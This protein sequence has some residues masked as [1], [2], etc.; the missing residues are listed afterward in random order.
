MP[1]S[2][3]RPAWVGTVALIGGSLAVW[4]GLS[5]LLSTT[6]RAP[7]HDVVEI[8][9]RF[10]SLRLSKGL[11]SAEDGRA[12]GDEQGLLGGGGLAESAGRGV[13]IGSGGGLSGSFGAAGGSFGLASSRSVSRPT[14]VPPRDVPSLN[15]EE[16]GAWTSTSQD[17]V[18][19]FAA[20]VDTG[21]YTYARALL[22][23]GAMPD[24][25][26]VRVE[27]FV[28]Y[29]R[30]TAVSPQSGELFN[31]QSDVILPPWDGG[32]QLVRLTVGSLHETRRPPCHLTFLVDTSGSMQ[33][34]H[35]LPLVREGLT[36]LVEALEEG[37]TVAIVAYAGSAGL[38][39]PPTDVRRSDRILESIENLRSGGS[40]AMGSGIQLAYDLAERTYEP[41][42]VNRVVLLSD[43][44][45]NVGPT[46]H[47]PLVET[48]RH[49]ASQGIALTT[50]GVGTGNY[51]DDMM[52]RLAD[53]GDGNYVYVDDL[54]EARRVFV[55]RLPSTLGVLARDVKLQVNWSP[56]TVSAYR[57]IGYENRSIADSDFRVDSVDAGEVGPGHQ[58][59][60]LYEIRPAGARAEGL[61]RVNIR[62]KPPG[63]DAPAME[64]SFGIT[65]ERAE[66]WDVASADT[67]LAVSAAVFADKLR[68]GPWS[69][70]V[71]W[72]QLGGWTNALAEGSSED[73]R[74]LAE[75]VQRIADRRDG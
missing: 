63:P 69:D 64:R 4:G 14:T 20:D 11:Q 46:S 30:Y 60:A 57:L 52:E 44:D 45:A 47:G 24:A 8:P 49:Y 48:V 72:A 37:D 35:K 23:R 41:G 59:T 65:D 16:T 42:Q 61:G 38:V 67:R 2:S 3:S 58:I 70:E 74:E 36:L 39:L 9:D 68:R 22:S 10:L 75:M 32:T 62:Y 40:T 55:H 34:Q 31:L 15:L 1:S 12:M 29:F 54:R 25:A 13:Q 26:H 28:N 27:E 66:A 50:V 6:P 21:S 7:E 43:G 56:S 53:E 17:R 51:R 33:S 19:T 18:S 71:D 5:L 73:L